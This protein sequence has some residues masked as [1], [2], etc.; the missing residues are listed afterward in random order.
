MT[1][2]FGK[3]KHAEAQRILEDINT[4]GQIFDSLI[5]INIP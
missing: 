2:P 5:I 3:E 1:L 4:K